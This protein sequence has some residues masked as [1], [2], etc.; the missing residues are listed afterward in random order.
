MLY[1]PS[2]KRL[3]CQDQE[4]KAAKGNCDMQYKHASLPH[5]CMSQTDEKLQDV[6]AISE[7][8]K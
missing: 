7:V 2:L 6:T 8:C 3:T 1:T 5:T 4:Q